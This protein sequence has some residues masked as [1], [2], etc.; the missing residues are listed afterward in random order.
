MSRVCARSGSMVLEQSQNYCCVCDTQFLICVCAC[1]LFVRSQAIAITFSF[2]TTMVVSH[3]LADCRVNASISR[4]L[5]SASTATS[6]YQGPAASCP[7]AH[8]FPFASV[9]WLVIASPLVALPP[10]CIAFRRTAASRVHPQPPP[11][12]FTWAGCCVASCRTA[13]ASGRTAGSRVASCGTSALHPPARPL[14][15]RHFCRPLSRRRGHPGR[16]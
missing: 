4:P 11:S 15:H 5:D 1:D 8:F 10:P 2:D 16:P 3:L 14:L 13:S 6:A 12:L 7:L 9:C